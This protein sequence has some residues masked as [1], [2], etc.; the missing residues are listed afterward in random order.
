MAAATE[1]LDRWLVHHS[2]V[3]IPAIDKGGGDLRGWRP[4]APG[5][6]GE[7]EAMAMAVSGRAA[8]RRRAGRQR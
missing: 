7:E 3:T 5:G 4:A 8:L 1:S 6:Q 2:A